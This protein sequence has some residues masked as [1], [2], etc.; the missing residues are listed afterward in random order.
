MLHVEQ[1]EA[2]QQAQSHLFSLT[3]YLEALMENFPLGALCLQEQLVEGEVRRSLLIC[4]TASFA[5]GC[6]MC[7]FASVQP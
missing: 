3:S 2:I 6:T 1:V 5:S 4:H 7:L